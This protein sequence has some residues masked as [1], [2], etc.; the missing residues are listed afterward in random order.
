MNEDTCILVDFANIHWPNLREQKACLIQ[1]LDDR[2]ELY[3]DNTDDPLEAIL[4]VIDYIQDEARKSL[5]TKV[6]FG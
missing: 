3:C 6:V 1:V 2:A 5:G 4:A